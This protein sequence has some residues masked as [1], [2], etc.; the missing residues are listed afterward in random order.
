MAAKVIREDSIKWEKSKL[1]GNKVE[2]QELS[3]R[4]KPP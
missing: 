2:D 1:R 4:R 3:K